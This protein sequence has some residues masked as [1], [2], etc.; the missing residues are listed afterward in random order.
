M[1]RSAEMEAPQPPSGDEWKEDR[2]LDELRETLAQRGIP[3]AAAEVTKD[4]KIREDLELVGDDIEEFL[5]WIHRFFGTD[6]SEL[7]LT[8]YFPQEGEFF[9]FIYDIR[10]KTGHYDKTLRT[11]K[12]GALV[13]AIQ[14]GRWTSESS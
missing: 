12:I 7:D 4:T 1:N 8:E 10:K 14:R 9:G 3:S 11:M 13:R 2:I 5:N 6:F